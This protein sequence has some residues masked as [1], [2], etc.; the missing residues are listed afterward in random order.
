MPMKCQT[1]KNIKLVQ[2]EICSIFGGDVL[3]MD[4]DGVNFEN[5]QRYIPMSKEEFE[6]FQQVI[7]ERMFQ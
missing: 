7:R 4:G 1:C 2:H 3:S 6:M 5:C